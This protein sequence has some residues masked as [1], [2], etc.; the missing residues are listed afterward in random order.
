MRQKQ[1]SMNDRIV[2]TKPEGWHLDGMSLYLRVSRGADGTLN[3]SWLFRYAAVGKAH[4]RWMG[5]GSYP[6]VSLKEAREAA[7]AARQARRQGIDP[8]DSKRAAKVASDVATAKTVT[9]ADMGKSYIASHSAGWRN[10]RHAAQWTSTLSTYVYPVFGHLP[11]AEV[12]V[13]LVLKVL[14]PIWVTKP[15][16]ASR[17]RGRI[18]A[19]LDAAKARG[20]FTKENPARL[21]GHLENLLPRRQKLDQAHHAAMPFVD[22]PDFMARLAEQE[23]N[24]ARAL[25]FTILTAAR[26]GEALGARWSEIDL[27][28][29]TWTVPAERMKAGREHRVPLSAPA[30]AILERQYEIREGNL[31]FPG[32]RAGRRMAGNALL[33][34]MARMGRDDL[35][36]HGFR[37]SFRDFAA[38]RTGVAREVA[39]GCLAHAIGSQVEAAYRRS[40][41]FDKRWHLMDAW[42]TFC[43][44]PISTG[45]VVMPFARQA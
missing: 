29:K 28:A 12:D 1:P 22:M 34:L 41:L 45:V 32:Q 26:S 5:L 42:S 33:K 36:T 24:P 3:R 4:D 17:V 10:A 21:R 35:T 20:L 23:G 15:E 18:E 9:F 30:I 25:A 44:T 19:V 38:E 39:E 8:I 43:M 6:D 7:S 16:T 13:D 2:Q 14:E 11:V 27:A 37:S 40:D 31:V